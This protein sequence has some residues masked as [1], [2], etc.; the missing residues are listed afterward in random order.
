MTEIIEFS[1]PYGYISRRRDSLKHV[2]E[3]KK[4]KYAELAKELKKQRGEDVRVTAVIVSSMGA[5]YLPS[6]KDLQKALRC[7]DEEL[8]QLG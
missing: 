7:S 6:L 8:R 5:V 2:Y 4:R 1:C 3:E